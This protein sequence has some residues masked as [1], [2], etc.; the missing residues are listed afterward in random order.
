MSTEIKNYFIHEKLKIARCK[1]EYE[2]SSIAKA[3]IKHII[4]NLFMKDILYLSL[5]LF[6]L[7]VF[8]QNVLCSFN[9]LLNLYE[10]N[11]Y[12]LLSFIIFTAGISSSN[13]LSA[14]QVAN[15]FYLCG[16]QFDYFHLRFNQQ[17]IYELLLLID[18]FIIA[19]NINKIARRE[20][21]RREEKRRE[22]KRREEKRRE[23]KRREE[24]RREAIII[25]RGRR[26]E[27]IC[28]VAKMAFLS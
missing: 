19:L 25:S 23:E 21:K 8:L 18:S 28:P 1:E 7:D 9:K 6:P 15:A 16:F 4:I 13:D 24:K 22:E 2:D 10:F 14:F 26:R 11:A 3:I 27:M 12:C 20:E 17:N 5:S